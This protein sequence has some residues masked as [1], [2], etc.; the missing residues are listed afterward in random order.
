MFDARVVPDFDGNRHREHGGNIDD[1]EQPQRGGFE[2]E[3][4]LFAETH[5]HG[6]TNELEPDW[7]KQQHNLP[8]DLEIANHAPRI[9]RNAEKHE[10]REIPNAFLWT[11]LA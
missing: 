10:G 2:V 3:E 7:H 8:V 4:A 6:L 11:C 5:T 9:P 1:D